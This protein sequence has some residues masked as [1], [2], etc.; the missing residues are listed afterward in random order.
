MKYYKLKDNLDVTYWYYEK[1]VIY[2]EDAELPGAVP[3]RNVLRVHP[4][5]WVEVKPFVYGK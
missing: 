2:R 3:L 4:N 1:G 5:H